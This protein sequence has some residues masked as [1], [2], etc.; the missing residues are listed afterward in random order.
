MV[1]TTRKNASEILASFHSFKSGLN[2][3]GF[4]VCFNQNSSN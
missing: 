2:A 1:I 4:V 3:F